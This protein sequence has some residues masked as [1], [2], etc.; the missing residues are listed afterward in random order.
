MLTRSSSIATAMND[1][2]GQIPGRAAGRI[3]LFAMLRPRVLTVLTNLRT[4]GFVLDFCGTLTMSK[5]WSRPRFSRVDVL[6]PMRRFYNPCS[7]IVA[8]DSAGGFRPA[9]WGISRETTSDLI[10]GW[11]FQP[12]SWCR[13]GWQHE[14]QCA[15][16]E[17]RCDMDEQ[18]QNSVKHYVSVSADFQTDLCCTR[19][20]PWSWT[21]KKRKGNINT[22]MTGTFARHPMNFQTNA[23]KNQESWIP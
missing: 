3:P 12:C 20:G 17:R 6:G 14:D 18:A 7:Y 9:R 23:E 19:A 10:S 2:G 8:R 13:C 5:W 4:T 21:Q 22:E 1:Y 11:R 15:S 16:H